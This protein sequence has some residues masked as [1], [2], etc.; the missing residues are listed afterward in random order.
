M[1]ILIYSRVFAPSVGGIETLMAILAEEF[2]AAG[3]TVKVVTVTQGYHDPSSNEYE[4]YRSPKPSKFV[5]LLRWSDVCLTANVS[6][7]GLVPMLLAQRP[8]VLS[9]HGVYDSGIVSSL[10]RIVA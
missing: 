10:K 7:R 6:L 2:V 8:I 4:I 3:H 9:H 5:R 1:N